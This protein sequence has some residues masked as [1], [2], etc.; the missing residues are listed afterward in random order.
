MENLLSK[1]LPDGSPEDMC[2]QCISLSHDSYVDRE[3]EHGCITEDDIYIIKQNL[4]EVK[5]NY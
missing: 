2:R 1:P 4:V 5:E 3:Y